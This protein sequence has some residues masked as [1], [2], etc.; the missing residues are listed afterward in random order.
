MRRTLRQRFESINYLDIVLWIFRLTIIVVVVWGTVATIRSNPYTGEQWLN[1]VI[2]GL[3]QGSLYALI[4]L[5]YTLVYGVLLMI[6]FAHGEFFMSGVF[7]ATVFV[8]IP[9]DEAGLWNQYPLICVLVVTAVAI[10]TS[11][12]IAVYE[13]YRQLGLFEGAAEKRGEPAPPELLKGSF[14]PVASLPGRI[15]TP[16]SRG[17]TK[18][19]CADCF[20][21]QWCSDSRCTRCRG[22]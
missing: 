2:A 11:V 8:A 14:K 6:N 15:F 12:G 20:S 10:L 16:E 9:L 18:H 19:P 4:A 21:C 22:K 17:P 1:L 5:G 7:T 13:G 3:T